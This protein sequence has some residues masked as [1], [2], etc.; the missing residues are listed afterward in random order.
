[1]DD[2]FEKFGFGV[3]INL[4]VGLPFR[5]ENLAFCACAGQFVGGGNFR[6]CQSGNALK[7]RAFALTG[8]SGNPDIDSFP[9]E[10]LDQVRN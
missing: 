7:Q 2:F 3:K 5:V 4:G 1:M 10:S 8:F 6:F 9:F